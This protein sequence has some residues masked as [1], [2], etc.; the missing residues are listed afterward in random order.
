MADEKATLAS[1]QKEVGRLV[2]LFN[3][4]LAH[5]S[6]K[7]YDE[8]SLR[9]EFLNPFFRALGWD[10]ENKA[11]RI[12]KQRD[13]EIES[14]TE[15]SGRTK[16]ADFLFRIEGHER[17]VCEAK[18][19]GHALTPAAAFQAKRYAWNAGVSWALLTDF[20]SWRLYVVGS[21]PHPDEPDLGLWKSWSS[22]ELPLAA[23]EIWRLL[24]RDSVAG[25]IIEREIDAIPK[26][27]TGKGKARQQWLIKPDRT[28][29]LDVDFLNF[30]DD[31]RREL[32]SDLLKHNDREDLLEGTKLNEAVQRII[33]RILF[34][35]I[36]EDREIDTGKRLTSFLR[37]ERSGGAWGKTRQ[38]ALLVS[39]AKA[40]YVAGEKP[41]APAPEG[42]IW[43]SLARHFGEL[44]RRP[45]TQVPFFNGNL[46]KK[47]FCEELTI[48]DDWLGD[49]IAEL[50]DDESPYLFIYIPVEILGTIYERFLGKV[51]RPKGRGATI[52]EKPEVRKA[53]GVYYTPRYIVDYIVEQTVGKQLDGKTAEES[54]TL[55]ILDPACGSGSFLIRA[56]EKV[57]E[58]WQEWLMANPKKARREW[59]WTDPATNDIHLTSALKRRIL[60]STIFGV[61][62]DSAAVEVTQLSLYLKMLED[63]NRTTLEKERELFGTD[64][65]LL[66]PLQDNIKNGNSLIASDFSMLPDD[67]VRV[68]AFDWPVQFKDIMK[69][70]G[71]DAIIGNPPYGANFDKED[72]EYIRRKFRSVTNSLDSFIMFVEQAGELL[73]QEGYFGMI[74]PSGWVSTPSS[75]KLRERFAEQFRP[76]SFVS[77]PYDVFDGAYIDTI[78]VTAKAQSTGKS[79]SELRNSAVDLVVFPIRMQVEGA[80]DFIA[81][82]KEG[83]FADWIKTPNK[84]FLVLSSREQAALVKKLRNTP[85]TLDSVVEIMRGIE[86]YNPRP[87][88]EC[89]K[90]KRAFNGEMLRYELDLG[91]LAYE[92]YPPDIETG[93]PIKFFRGP[94]ILLRQLLSRKFRLQAV[95]AE[96]EF[97]T[98]QSV[99]SL[100]PR[101]EFPDIKCC[102]AI[103]NSRLLSWL[104]CQINLVARRDDFPKTI[105]KQTRELPFPKLEEEIP[106]D[107][108]RHDR[109]IKLVDKM[110][111]LTP[112]LRAAKAESE[113]QT[114]QNAV[115]ATDQ[116]IDQL[117][118][119]LYGLTKEEIAL[120]EGGQWDAA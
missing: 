52:E 85:T 6:E 54:L 70:G 114:L 97:L 100:I 75:K 69:S 49:F 4:N 84:E 30:L 7:G 53:G 89:R 59:C 38:P 25:G 82:R 118:Y 112:K 77:L 101:N 17:F 102:L 79:W 44:D 64:D 90:P 2:E 11:G 74:I 57:C 111:S 40:E 33:D 56:F 110:I 71:F 117:V 113:K 60:T 96:Q 63:E 24:G 51:V 66:P 28:R 108:K 20:D 13:V 26:K 15:I 42:A 72:E 93:K 35:R 50:S 27:A 92:G 21:K 119:E 109:L 18:R 83:D 67:L 37:G 1:F 91:P 98:N 88:K 61:D 116:E 16:R 99:Q 105:I 58:H 48:G 8:A 36:C 34:L 12:P 31:A 22:H 23:D 46:F 81:Y 65:P 19:P 76:T 86:T 87:S 104:F 107:K 120:I 106:A 55:K 5:Y 3:R 80:K 68:H 73:N 45:P 32:A 41:K 39:E 94:R 29:S 47:H 9:N 95:Y 62:L 78:I 43:R 10:V 14:R 115:D 103:L